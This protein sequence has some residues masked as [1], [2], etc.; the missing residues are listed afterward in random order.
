MRT[1]SKVLIALVLAVAAGCGDDD[2]GGGG[3]SDAEQPFVDAS[4]ES[5]QQQFGLSEEDAECASEAVVHAI[6]VDRLEDADVTPEEFG[7]EADFEEM[8]L[9]LDEDDGEEIV[10]GI[11]D[12]DID[13]KALML[14]S[15]G[16]DI[17]DEAR[18]C[19]DENLDED[20]VRDLLVAV[21][22]SGEE[23]LASPEVTEGLTDLQAAC[24]EAF[25][26]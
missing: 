19:V 17:P 3:V 12:C 25:G 23:A 22:S 2:D 14:D 6:G 5:A 18:D 21:F 10:N 26:G 8:G 11:E 16:G 13:L 7:G 4:V 1:L 24:P 9:E 15:V 20:F